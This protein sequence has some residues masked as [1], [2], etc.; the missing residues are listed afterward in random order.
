M[1]N[2][3]WSLL[4]P[5][6][7]Q[8]FRVDSNLSGRQWALLPYSTEYVLGTSWLIDIQGMEKSLS[9]TGDSGDKH[10]EY[11]LCSGRNKTQ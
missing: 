8:E 10:L 7:R 1:V 6:F 2:E 9:V 3:F 5:Y 11:V 4:S